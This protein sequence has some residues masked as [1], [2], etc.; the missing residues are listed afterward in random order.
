MC[1]FI[2]VSR[3]THFKEYI[4]RLDWQKVIDQTSNSIEIMDIE[5]FIYH[6]ESDSIK[7]IYSLSVI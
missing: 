3:Y 5:E 6:Y 7:F 2:P 4:H 1:T